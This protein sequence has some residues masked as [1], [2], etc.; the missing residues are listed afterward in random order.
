MSENVRKKIKVAPSGEVAELIRTASRGGGSVIVEIDNTAYAVHVE[1]T[2][3]PIR[4]TGRLR[5]SKE[6]REAIW[7]DY[8]PERARAALHEAAG[9]WSDID[10]DELVANIYRWREEGSRPANRS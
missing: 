10:T 2:A 5:A 3:A 4:L 1:E 9:S 6:E 8:D 7:K